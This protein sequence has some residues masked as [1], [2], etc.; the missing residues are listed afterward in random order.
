MGERKQVKS[1]LHGPQPAGAGQA[2]A[3][4]RQLLST[5]CVPG[6]HTVSRVAATQGIFSLSGNSFLA[7]FLLFSI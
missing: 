7:S 5:Y 3:E 1:Y 2:S 4:G 6:P